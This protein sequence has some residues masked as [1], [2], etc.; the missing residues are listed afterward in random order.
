M[1]ARYTPWADPGQHGRELTVYVF[2][3]SPAYGEGGPMAQ[4]SE[5]GQ[6]HVHYLGPEFEYYNQ[7]RFWFDFIRSAEERLQAAGLRSNGVACGDR[8]LPGCEFASLRNEAFVRLLNPDWTE[9]SQLPKYIWEYPPNSH[10]W[11]GACNRNP[12]E[13]TIMLLEVY[14]EAKKAAALEAS[15]QGM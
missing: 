9:A 2:E 1:K 15:P 11:N 10:G 7:G 14:D 13:G 5:V 4:Y 8:P 6:E 3:H 12:L